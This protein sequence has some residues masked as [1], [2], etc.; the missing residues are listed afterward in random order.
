MSS[1]FY[2]GNISLLHFNI[3][4]IEEPNQ[5]VAMITALCIYTNERQYQQ[6]KREHLQTIKMNEFL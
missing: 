2:C 5:N 6:Q 1:A 3:Q 4:A